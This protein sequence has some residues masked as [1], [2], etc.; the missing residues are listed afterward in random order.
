MKKLIQVAMVAAAMAAPITGAISFA[1][2][3]EPTGGATWA[4]A[5]G[6]DFVDCGICAPDKV[7]I[8]VQGS[9]SC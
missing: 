6:I 2:G 9:G 4:T 1:G 7:A 3:A 5:T 8:I